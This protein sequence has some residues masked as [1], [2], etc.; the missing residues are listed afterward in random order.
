M[1]PDFNSSPKA[2]IIY[3]DI[4]TEISRVINTGHLID[5]RSNSP[6]LWV[7]IT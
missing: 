7:G 4:S 6:P 5:R 3:G 2:D 1:E